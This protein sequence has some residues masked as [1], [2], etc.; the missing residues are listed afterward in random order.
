MT[1]EI[2]YRFSIDG[3]LKNIFRVRDEVQLG[4]HLPNICEALGL[5]PNI[6]KKKT[7]TYGL[8]NPWI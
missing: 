4:E 2:L 3:I 8:L 5:S 6:K 1:K 7:K